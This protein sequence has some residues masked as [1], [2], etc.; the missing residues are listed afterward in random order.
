MIYICCVK[1]YFVLVISF[2]FILIV[3]G[4]FVYVSIIF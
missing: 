3:V 1:L 4:G 2:F